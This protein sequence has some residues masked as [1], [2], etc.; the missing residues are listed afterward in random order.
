MNSPSFHSVIQHQPWLLGC[1][2]VPWVGAIPTLMQLNA[3]LLK[4]KISG[5]C[6]SSLT[7]KLRTFYKIKSRST[8]NIFNSI[9][10]CHFV[11]PPPK[12]ICLSRRANS[13]TASHCLQQKHFNLSQLKKKHRHDIFSKYHSVSTAASVQILCP[14][15]F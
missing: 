8:I 5:E 7:P 14:L 10:H 1:R 9:Y 12:V 11:S 13:Q 6:A 2:E 4:N 3:T 15:V